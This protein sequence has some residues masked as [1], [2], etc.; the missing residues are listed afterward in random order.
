MDVEDAESHPL[1]DYYS[2]QYASSREEENGAMQPV[3]FDPTSRLTPVSEE[4]RS[5]DY[6]ED[7]DADTT[8][9]EVEDDGD[10]EQVSQTAA[11]RMAEKR[12]MKRF[13]CVSIDSY[14]QRLLNK[15]LQVDTQSDSILVK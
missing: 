6:T 11:E 10:G 2:V 1:L 5:D 14:Y 7:G 4:D 12:K 9:A 8:A 3:M 15:L 13:R